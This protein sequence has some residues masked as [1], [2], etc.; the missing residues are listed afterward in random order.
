MLL[1][2]QLNSFAS[3]VLNVKSKEVDKLIENRDQKIDVPSSSPRY[4]HIGQAYQYRWPLNWNMNCYFGEIA[5]DGYNPF[6][7]KTFNELSDSKLKD[8]IWKNPFYYLTNN[9]S[10]KVE[11]LDFKINEIKL[12]VNN[13]DTNVLSLAQNPYPGWHVLVNDIES[14]IFISNISHQSVKLTNAENIVIWRYDNKILN[15][16]F[17]IHIIIFLL[18]IISYFIL[19]IQFVNLHKIK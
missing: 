11:L 9:Q 16:I 17:I 1:S 5:I 13:S 10:S 19:Y 15:F 4:T 14:P 12:K 2:I 8:S 3:M 6:V 7:L 18:L